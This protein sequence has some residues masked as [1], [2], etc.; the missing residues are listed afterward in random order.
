MISAGQNITVT[1]QQSEGRQ[2]TK[3]PV[4]ADPKVS[5]KLRQ[6]PAPSNHPFRSLLYAAPRKNIKRTA[7][8]EKLFPSS[9]AEQ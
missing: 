8:E 3:D 5:K 6:R 2:V 7:P 1:P 4:G 9:R